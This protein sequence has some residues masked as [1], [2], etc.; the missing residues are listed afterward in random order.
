MCDK[1]F[2]K[3]AFHESGHVVMTYKMGYK[4]QEVR[5]R[6]P[7]PVSG[8]TQTHYEQDH[9][10]VGGII[11]YKTSSSLFNS[12]PLIVKMRSVETAKKILVIELSGPI[13]ETLYDFGTENKG[14]LNIELWGID[15]IDVE[16]IE[17]F[18]SKYDKNYDENFKKNCIEAITSYL[19]KAEI[20]DGITYM[21]KQLLESPTKILSGIKIEEIL[22]KCNLLHKSV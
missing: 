4:V 7:D 10:L 14:N 13:T 6:E 18:L 5:L 1:T 22:K 19:R 2:E 9:L 11:T 12:F 20:W 3:A 16:N 21:S 17:F 15:K 8:Y